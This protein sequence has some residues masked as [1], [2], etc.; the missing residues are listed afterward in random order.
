M[1]RIIPSHPSVTHFTLSSSDQIP[2]F[3]LQPPVPRFFCTL[4][5]PPHV[6]AVG[7]RMPQHVVCSQPPDA[8]AGRRTWL[9]QVV[10]VSRR[11]SPAATT[12]HGSHPP[13][14]T[15][16]RRRLL[17]LGAT[18]TCVLLVVIKIRISAAV[19]P[20][21]WIGCRFSIIQSVTRSPWALARKFGHGQYK[22]KWVWGNLGVDPYPPQR[23][24]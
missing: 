24:V 8:A 9:P 20:R 18:T 21:Q 5:P 12:G 3:S 2:N 7:R 19:G 23:Q 17:Q 13:A 15:V 16:H 11:G 14:A 1:G 4:P 10:A 22:L 6:V